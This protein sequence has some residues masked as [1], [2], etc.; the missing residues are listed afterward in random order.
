MGRG[1][2]IVQ[3]AAQ[4]ACL[5]V[6]RLFP[7]VQTP[8]TASLWAEAC[9]WANDALNRS[10]TEANPGRASPWTRFCGEAPPLSMLPFF[11]PGYCCIRRDSKAAPKAEMCFYLNGGSNHPS[12]LLKSSSRP[13]RSFTPATSHGFILGSHSRYPSRPGGED[14]LASI[15]WNRDRR[16]RRR[17]SSSSSLTR[18]SDGSTRSNNDRSII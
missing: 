7:D 9:F 5:E 2:A 13:A 14:L 15:F 3:E 8:A 6:P 16:R 11:K 18:D 12:L 10:A 1:L 17:R 4:A